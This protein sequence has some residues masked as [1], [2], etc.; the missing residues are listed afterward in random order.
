M[1]T[2][3]VV[4]QSNN[5]AKCQITTVKKNEDGTWECFMS[6]PPLLMEMTTVTES[7]IEIN[8]IEMGPK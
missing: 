7:Y 8:Y 5:F 3:G 4:Y 2:E 6:H 1:V